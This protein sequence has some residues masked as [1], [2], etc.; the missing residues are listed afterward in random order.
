MWVESHNRTNIATHIGFIHDAAP[1]ELCGETC[2]NTCTTQERTDLP[3][4]TEFS[5][6]IL[7]SF[8]RFLGEF[9]PRS[10]VDP[11]LDYSVEF[12]D[13]KPTGRWSCGLCCIT[14]PDINIITLHMRNDHK[15]V[16]CK[17]CDKTFTT[18]LDMDNHYYNT[19]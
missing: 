1:Y 12:K 2:F 10:A 3:T 13:R 8:I 14:D 4:S 9:H 17:K 5:P 7:S 6:M 15:L 11:A 16:K 18:M 19:H